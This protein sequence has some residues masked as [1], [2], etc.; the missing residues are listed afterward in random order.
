MIRSKAWPPRRARSARCEA[1]RDIAE[2][3]NLLALNAT[4]EAA[5]AGEAGKGFAVV[6]ARGEESGQP[7]AKA[8]EEISAK[9][10]E[11]QSATGGS[12][13]AIKAIA[14]TIGQISE[15]SAT[16]AAAVEEQSA[17]TPGNLAQCSAGRGRH[18][19]VNANITSV[20]EGATRPRRG[21]A[22]CSPPPSSSRR[23]PK[24]CVWRSTGSR[25][26]LESRL[27]TRRFQTGI[28]ARGVIRAALCV[29]R[30]ASIVVLWL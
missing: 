7:D 25:A 20:T 10:G 29:A 8:T 11:M 9:I 19:G 6:A 13:G 27:D 2:Q 3:T 17:A 24:L 12:V 23:R 22:R 5:R 21:G 18:P 30:V 26:R 15:I 1:D 16:I 4:I 14:E 28:S